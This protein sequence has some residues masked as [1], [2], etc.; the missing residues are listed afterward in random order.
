MGRERCQDHKIYQQCSVCAE[1]VNDLLVLS[2]LRVCEKVQESWWSRW[3]EPEDLLL[4]IEWWHHT[5]QFAAEGRRQKK[6]AVSWLSATWRLGIK[7]ANLLVT[8]ERS[9]L[10]LL[11]VNNGFTVIRSLFQPPC[12]I[13]VTGELWGCIPMFLLFL[14]PKRQIWTLMQNF[15]DFLVTWIIL[16]YFSYFVWLFCLCKN[17]KCIICNSFFCPSWPRLSWKR[18]SV[19][20]NGS[21]LV[22]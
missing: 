10:L 8:L 7:A 6:L 12:N 22:K 4:K 13:K 14:A 17:L 19:N 3:E 9:N 20:P 11:F 21:Y 1:P 18:D 2:S 16:I 15:D 5:C